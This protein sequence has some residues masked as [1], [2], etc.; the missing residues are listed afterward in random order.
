MSR[1][2]QKLDFEYFRLF[3]QALGFRSKEEYQEWAKKYNE[4]GAD[5]AWLISEQMAKSEGYLTPQQRKSR[6]IFH[7]RY[8]G[9]CLMPRQRGYAGAPMTGGKDL[10]VRRTSSRNGSH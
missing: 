3:V 1:P 6:E 2:T 7:S 9:A 10:T 4:V 5:Q 8:S